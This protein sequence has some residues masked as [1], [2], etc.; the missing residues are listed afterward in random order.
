[1]LHF[2]RDAGADLVRWELTELAHGGPCRL[3]VH[4]TQGI[5]VE[6]HK[7]PTMA[8]LR[9]QELEQRLTSDSEIEDQ[10]PAGLPS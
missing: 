4:H 9:L 5:I 10:E 8:I 1:M 2:L 3:A 7:S 6:Y